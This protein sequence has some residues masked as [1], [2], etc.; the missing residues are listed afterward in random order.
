MSAWPR[1]GAGL[2]AQRC[3]PD[4]HSASPPTRVGRTRLA[5][6]MQSLVLLLCLAAPSAAAAAAAL[7]VQAPELPST[8]V[9][10]APAPAA[11]A[12][13]NTGLVTIESDRQQ[14]DQATGVVTATGNVRILYPDQQVVVTARQAQ[15]FSREN[16]LVLSG[17]VDIVQEGGNLL[18]AERVVYLVDSERLTAIPEQGQ[19]VFSRMRLP[20]S[21]NA[22]AP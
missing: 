18:R 10:P 8:P 21:P 17:E 16:R 6:S 7:P 5:G 14:A 2:T 12:R 9:T 13:L 1:H 15:F 22:T 3:S 4:H 11:P 19:Q 20:T